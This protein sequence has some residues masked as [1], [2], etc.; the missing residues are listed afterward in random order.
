[1]AT[2]RMRLQV[3]DYVDD[4]LNLV[5]KIRTRTSN[6]LLKVPGPRLHRHCDT[7]MTLH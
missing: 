6:E 4:P 3:K 5:G 2:T 7:Q 1:M